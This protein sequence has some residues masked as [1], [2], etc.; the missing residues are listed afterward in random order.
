MCIRDSIQGVNAGTTKIFD[1]EFSPTS[2]L[3]PNQS[4][5]LQITAT[6]LTTTLTDAT[7]KVSL[8]LPMG[9]TYDANSSV[10][11]TPNSWT[12]MEPTIS[13]SNGYQILQWQL[14]IGLGQ[15]E[16]ATFTFSVTSLD[17]DCSQL[18]ADAGLNTIEE[19]ILACA[20]AAINCPV[21][22]NTST[23]NG[24]LTP[25]P[26]S[27]NTLS[28]NFANISS[29]CSGVDEETIS[30]N[31]FIQN[32][33][34]AFPNQSFDVEYY[35]DADNS[36]NITSGDPVVATF[37]E[38]GPIAV[39]GSIPVAHNFPVSENQVCG[40]IAFIDSTGLGICEVM[41]VPLGEP[42]LL[43]AGDDQIFC[44]INPTTISA[45]LGNPTCGSISNYTFNWLAISPASTSDLSATNIPCL[46]YTSPSPRD[47]TLS[48]M[49]S[50]A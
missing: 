30:V 21:E 36:G 50:S 8:M 46:L 40:I 20:A 29:D 34:T 5:T 31:G 22:A 10:A 3:I 1:I 24:A 49:P 9:V 26:I 38:S 27:Q 4:S 2:S 37:T 32:S 7:D 16:E 39:N 13:M 23:N 17:F 42:Q 14:P 35:F 33:N 47:A 41:E 28:F 25:I 12:I 18:S 45:N 48:R 15:S 44:E 6:N 43:N 11:I 19:I